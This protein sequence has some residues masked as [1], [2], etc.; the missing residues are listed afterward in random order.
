MLSRTLHPNPSPLERAFGDKSLERT[1]AF[2]HLF[3]EILAMMTSLFLSAESFR[4][5]PPAKSLLERRGFLLHS[6]SDDP[7]QYGGKL[8]TV[9]AVYRR[10]NK[11]GTVRVGID[12]EVL[13]G[14][15]TVETESALRHGQ[16]SQSRKRVLQKRPQ[17]RFTIRS[18]FSIP[19][20]VDKTSRSVPGYFH[21]TLFVDGETVPTGSG[22]VCGEHGEKPWLVEL[23]IGRLEMKHWMGGYPQDPSQVRQELGSPG[24]GRYYYPVRS[25]MVIPFGQ[26]ADNTG[27]RLQ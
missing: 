8:E 20:R 4:F 7:A 1:S 13:V 19:I 2:L 26:D 12:P 18:D 9:T 6:V 5:R 10:H 27:I 23:R 14:S 24:S 21:D 15:V 22:N 25:E 11:P 17:T 16:G 3:T